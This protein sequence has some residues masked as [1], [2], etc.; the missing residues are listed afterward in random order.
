MEKRDEK[1]S[2]LTLEQME[3]VSG[4]VFNFGTDCFACPGTQS[5]GTRC[6]KKLQQVSGI[7]YR[8]S[9]PLCSLFGKDQFP[10]RSK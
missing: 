9:N 2:T 8:C 3:K 7:L 4:G 10:T 6:H 1:L 5:D